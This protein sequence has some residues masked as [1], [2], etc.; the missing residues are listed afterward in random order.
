MAHF[1]IYG[2]SGRMG[3]L[4]A[5]Y[6]SQH[7]SHKLSSVFVRRELGFSLPAET[8]VTNDIRTFFSSASIVVDFTSPSGTETLLETALESKRT[9]LVIGTTGLNAHQQN[10]LKLASEKMPVLYATNMSLGVALLNKLVFTASAALKDFDIE[11]TEMHHRHKKDAPSGTALTLA[12]TAAKAR[13]I[14][15]EST[16]VSG[17]NGAIGERGADE[18]GVLSLR[19]GD[20]VGEHTVGFYG[21]GEFIRLNHTATNRSTFAAGAIKAGSW[22]EG[23]PNGLYSIQDYFQL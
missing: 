16:M 6:L 2:A 12:S 22:L 21:D 14:A 1:S 13:E 19:G 17:R 23:Q 15:L 4:L 11:I 9:A 5:T 10:L 18:I 8:L 3:Q 20:I 7:Q